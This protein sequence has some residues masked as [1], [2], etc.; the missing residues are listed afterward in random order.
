MRPCTAASGRKAATVPSDAAT[1]YAWA[2]RWS[3]VRAAAYRELVASYTPEQRELVRRM[4]YAGA[5]KALCWQRA[6][7]PEGRSGKRG[8]VVAWPDEPPTE[9]QEE[10]R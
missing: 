4:N 1:L 2:R 10:Q 9:T 3:A 6:H 8:G 5:Q 7:F